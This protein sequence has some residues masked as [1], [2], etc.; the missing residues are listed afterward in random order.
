MSKFKQG[1]NPFDNSTLEIPHKN[2]IDIFEKIKL[3]LK[4]QRFSKLLQ[5]NLESGRYRKMS[6]NSFRIIGDKAFDYDQ[7]LIVQGETPKVKFKNLKIE[8]NY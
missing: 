3:R 1:G 5:R 8:V 6:K 4:V 7:Y 2:K